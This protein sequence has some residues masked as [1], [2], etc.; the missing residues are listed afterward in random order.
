[1]L[2]VTSVSESSTSSSSVVTT[3]RSGRTLPG[4][5]RHHVAGYPAI[6][7]S[8]AG[9]GELGD[10]AADQAKGANGLLVGRA[11]CLVELGLYRVDR[12]AER[13]GPAAQGVRDGAELLQRGDRGLP[14]VGDGGEPDGAAVEVGTGVVAEVL[15]VV[16]G[17]LDQPGQCAVVAGRDHDQAVGLPDALDQAP[18][19]V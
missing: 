16:E 10:L 1:M 12:R 9:Q 15:E 5:G 11:A 7:R 18:G 4:H 17:V 19:S 3:P 8:N 2:C 14:A 13:R 6:G